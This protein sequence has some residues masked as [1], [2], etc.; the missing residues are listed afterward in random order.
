[1]DNIEYVVNNSKNVK[2]NLEMIS[3]IV[4]KFD[5]HY[6]Y[7]HWSSYDKYFVTMS[8]KEL[9]LFSFILESLNFCFWPNYDWKV[10]YNDKEYLGSDA[11]LF[12]LLKAVKNKKIELNIESLYNLTKNDFLSFMK[13]NSTY[14]VLLDERFESLKE[15]INV[16]YHNKNF[17][18]ELF[19]L[20]TDIDLEQYIINNFSNYKDSSFYHKKEIIFNKRCRLLIGDLFYV[21][22]T[23]HKN[24]SNISQIKGCAD[25]SL[26]RFFREINLINYSDKLIKII[27]NGIEL[28]HG[29]DFEIEIRA[30]TL[31]LLEV[32]KKE[33]KKRKIILNSLELDNI[34]WCMSRKNRI[35]KPHHTIS[36]YY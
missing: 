3:S 10:K 33:L 8:E 31:Y 20:K 23:I 6:H 19:S 4:D 34:L 28:E 36:I 16:I 35:T 7:V 27:D 26:P 18:N 30:T 13:Q 22:R 9:I 17:W 5:N 32:I 15:T 14:P 2:I 24:I 21:S 25:Y 29:C 1:M 12:V 11:L